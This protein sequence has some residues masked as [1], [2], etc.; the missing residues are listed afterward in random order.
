[1]SNNLDLSQ[2]TAAQN[3]KEVTINDQAAEL[4]AAVTAAVDIAVD[5]SNAI[6]L[7]AAQ[8]R[9]SNMFH[10]VNDSPVPTAAITVTIP[11]VSRGVFAVINETSY[12]VTVEISGQSETSPTVATGTTE[13][14]SL[15]TCDG[16]DCRSAG[17]GGGGGGTSKVTLNATGKVVTSLA[18]NTQFDITGFI[19]RG[20]WRLLKITE[21]GGVSTGTYDV[22]IYSSDAFGA[23]D[24]LY[25]VD[26]IDS[27]AD[28]RI[29]TDRLLVGYED[30]DATTELHI[31]FDNND[32]A[33]SMT[34]TIDM[35]AEEHAA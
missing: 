21:T 4:D 22:R 13:N 12:E 23:G 31:E 30:D 15:I 7:T 17:G 1:M 6:T 32:A 27:T 35:I 29:F 9:G 33:Q 16:V 5:N 10:I 34:F 18:T 8:F 19:T 28:S 3:N 25:S 26:A 11:A 14:A 2:V 24:L 20:A